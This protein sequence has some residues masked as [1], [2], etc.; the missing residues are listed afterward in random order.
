[1]ST[2]LVNAR[3]SRELIARD[4][5]QDAQY[6]QEWERT[7]LARAVALVV[8]GYRARHGLTQRKLADLLGWKPSQVARLE[9]GEHNPTLDTLIHL[10]QRVGLRLVLT[11]GPSGGKR[12]GVRPA[13]G[14]V[15][16]EGDADGSHLLV[17]V[18][19]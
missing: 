8:V 14:D 13:K 1:M 6:K 15:V 10:S 2:R 3:P 12:P 9:L 11:I 17:A 18:G 7:A 4:L 5:E 19:A 16:Q